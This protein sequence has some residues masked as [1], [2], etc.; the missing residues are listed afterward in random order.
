MAELKTKATGK[1]VNKFLD[2]IKDQQ[3]RQDCET[4][5]E[6]MRKATGAEP[7]MWGSAI[8]GFGDCHYTYASGREGDWFL[9]GFSPRKQNLTLYVMG[10]YAPHGEL[11]EQLGKH[12]LGGGCLYLGKLEDVHMPTLRKLI[13]QS[14]ALA[15][16][17]NKKRI[18]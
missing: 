9:T 12:K 2:G 16:R 8:V 14:V 18:T 3:R 5:G 4:I 6:L 11:L 17:N 15:K 1:S 10:G 7:K 13:N